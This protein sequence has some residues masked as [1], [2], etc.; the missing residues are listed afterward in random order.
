MGK[1]VERNKKALRLSI[2]A[3]EHVVRYGKKPTW[4]KKYIARCPMCHYMQNCNI[5]RRIVDWSAT[6]V[7]KPVACLEKEGLFH[8]YE[9][10]MGLPTKN[11][12]A[13][14]IAKRLKDALSKI[15]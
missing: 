2:E 10:A 6:P 13:K 12:Y 15:N 11:L 3:W 7:V 4:T 1:A 14:M 5:C 8:K 9:H